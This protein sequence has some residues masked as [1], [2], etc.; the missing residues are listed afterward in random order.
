M[1]LG[2]KTIR[3]SKIMTVKE[4]YWKYSLFVLILGLG[5]TIFVELTPFLGGILGAVTI[6]VLLQ[7]LIHI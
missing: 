4:Q 5:A 1:P 7:S 3:H 6:Y 2:R